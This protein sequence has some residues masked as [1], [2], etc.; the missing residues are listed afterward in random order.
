[1]DKRVKGRAFIDGINQICND[2]MTDFEKALAI[3]DWIVKTNEYDNDTCSSAE[4]APFS[5]DNL[6]K[7]YSQIIYFMLCHHHGLLLNLLFF[8]LF[9]LPTH[10]K[11]ALT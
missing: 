10:P 3:H 1:M 6:T 5:S 7:M 8:F 4:G 11:Y 2:T 9:H